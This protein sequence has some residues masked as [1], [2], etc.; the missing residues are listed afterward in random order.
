MR[1]RSQM[2]VP[3]DVKAPV[4]QV[5]GLHLAATLCPHHRPISS[6]WLPF[7]AHRVLVTVRGTG[8]VMVSEKDEEKQRKR[9]S[10]Q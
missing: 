2:S 9:P 4:T 8:Q 5:T 7:H 6:V 10:K 3:R 1:T